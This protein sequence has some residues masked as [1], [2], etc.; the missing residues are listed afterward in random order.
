MKLFHFE[1]LFGSRSTLEFGVVDLI[2]PSL[3]IKYL[4]HL[5]LRNESSMIS[6]PIFCQILPA[7]VPYMVSIHPLFLLLPV[8]DDS[9]FPL[10]DCEATSRNRTHAV[11]TAHHALLGSIGVDTHASISATHVLSIASLGHRNV[12]VFVQ[13]NSFDKV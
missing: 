6:E 3:T 12:L 8:L 9:L 2:K 1:N 11:C 4:V 13:I 7:M 10:I 5:F